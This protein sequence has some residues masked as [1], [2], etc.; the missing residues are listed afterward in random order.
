[1]VSSFVQFL[2]KK[3]TWVP[4]DRTEQWHMGHKPR[5]EYRY[6]VDYY[7]AGAITYD[8]FINEYRNPEHYRPEHPD[9]SRSGKHEGRGQYWKE[10]FGRLPASDDSP[11]N[12]GN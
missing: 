5:R 1:M 7:I 10:K 6:L 2:I 11:E 9:A 3:L 8:T 4:G 12:G